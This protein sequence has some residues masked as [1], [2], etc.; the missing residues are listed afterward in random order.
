MQ[1]NIRNVFPFAVAWIGCDLP[2][3]DMLD[4]NVLPHNNCDCDILT[5]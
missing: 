5:M 4:D 3:D 1:S 2:D